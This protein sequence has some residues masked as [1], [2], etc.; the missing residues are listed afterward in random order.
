MNDSEVK[1]KTLEFFSKDVYATKTT[2]IVIDDI[3]EGYAKCSLGLTDKVLNAGGAVQGGALFTLCDFCF[4]V[5]ANSFGYR[6]VTASVNINF[7]KAATGDK[8]TAET[9]LLKKTK[10]L[11][12]YRVDVF[13]E[14]GEI[15]I[16]A[17]I[18]G[19]IKDKKIFLSEF[20]LNKTILN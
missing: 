1:K 3:K 5:A 8:V 20:N 13:D 7:L 6:C 2:G 14:S 4:A 17:Q 18:V 15:I 9:T 10:R 16:S 11:C 12:Y 19:Y